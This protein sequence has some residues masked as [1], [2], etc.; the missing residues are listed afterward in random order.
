M[1]AIRSYYDASFEGAQ[2][3]VLQKEQLAPAFFELRTGLAGAILQKFS[4]YRMKLAIC[5][6]FENI[7][8]KVV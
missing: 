1:Y 3:V 7:R 8:S 5:G 2:S 4:N 6:D